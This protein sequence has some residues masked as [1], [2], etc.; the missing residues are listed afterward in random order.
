M[1]RR[2]TV[3]RNS[4]YCGICIECKPEQDVLYGGVILLKVRMRP[5]SKGVRMGL[6]D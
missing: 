4:C 6:R 2:R 3:S 1:R 5:S